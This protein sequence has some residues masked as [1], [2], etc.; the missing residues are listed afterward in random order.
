MQPAAVGAVRRALRLLIAPACVIA[1]AAGEIRADSVA[2]ADAGAQEAL[3]AAAQLVQQGRLEEADRQARL[4]MDDPET[5]A[6]ACSVL[7]TIR[8]Q[9]QR[10]D[11]SAAFLREAIRLDANLLGAHINLAHV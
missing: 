3:R 11:E 9:Q 4:A 7:G 8:L 2:A 1:L 10:L 5:R 6:V